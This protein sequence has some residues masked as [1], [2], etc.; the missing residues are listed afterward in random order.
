MHRLAFHHTVKIAERDRRVSDHEQRV[1][2]ALDEAFS[3]RQHDAPAILEGQNQVAVLGE[4]LCGFRIESYVVSLSRGGRVSKNFISFRFDER[5]F[6]FDFS[7]DTGLVQ[8]L[9]FRHLR[10]L[11]RRQVVAIESRV[12][13]QNNFGAICEGQHQVVPDHLC[14]HLRKIEIQFEALLSIDKN[15]QNF[16]TLR[17]DHGQKPVVARTFV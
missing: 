10:S 15:A 12:A 13:N 14:R 9:D 7:Q 4:N 17:F 11:K 8:K 1:A 3:A 2:A 6:A 5:E 16:A